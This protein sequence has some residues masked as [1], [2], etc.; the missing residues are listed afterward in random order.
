MALLRLAS[1]EY[2][3]DI[4]PGDVAKIWR[5]GCIIR[6][7][8]LGDIRDAFRRDPDLVN[9]LLDEAFRDA[10]GAA[11]AGAGATSSRP[12]SASAFRCRP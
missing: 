7:A 8:L 4:D 3:Y 2:G 1:A 11:A 5:A 12:R 6:A 10:I 9:L